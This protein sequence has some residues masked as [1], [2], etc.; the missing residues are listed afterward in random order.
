MKFN[1]V[2]YIEWFKRKPKATYDLCRSGVE[3]ISMKDLMIDFDSLEISGEHDGYG[4]SP[5]I[6]S[7]ASK[8]KTSPDSIILTQGASHAIFVVCAALIDK[9][10]VIVEKPVYGPLVDVPEALGA[11]IIFSDRQFTGKYRF[12][13]GKISL[14][15]SSNTQLILLTNP[16]NP[17][18][19][20]L[21][22]SDLSEI[23]D[24][25]EKYNIPVI[26][27]E[28]YL[29]FL[30]DSDERSS[31]GLSKNIIV[32][33]S[34]TKVYGLGG[35]RCGW[36]AAH[37]DLIRVMRPLID[38]TI[39]EGVFPGEQISAQVFSQIE[40]I[41]AKKQKRLA[42]NIQLM[43]EFFLGEKN[44]TW[45][46]PP[47]G[48]ICFPKIE[49]DVSGDD[50]ASILKDK[51]DTAIVPGSFFRAP[52]HIRLGFDLEKELLKKALG[53]I[54]DAIVGSE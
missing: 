16:H 14:L 26:I 50:L 11:R 5:L 7:V 51:Y 23:I 46:E 22:D 17:S 15:V 44:L 28:I 52:Q 25:S 49:A 54:Q 20:Y 42:E 35:L 48:V 8:Y 53:N 36:I 3:N 4:Y 18:G 43:R 29:D 39:V 32:I 33:S 2:E 24:V 21:T 30:E 10:E 38:Y 13:S 12:E 45:I 1:K 41:K 40:E 9:G 37:P 34:L 47:G 31:F 6:A 19:V 27:D